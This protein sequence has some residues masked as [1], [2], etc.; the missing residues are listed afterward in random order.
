[1]QY[2]V[3]TTQYGVQNTDT[4]SQTDEQMD[5]EKRSPY[6]AFFTQCKRTYDSGLEG[7]QGE[8]IVTQFDVL[9]RHLLQALEKTLLD[10]RY[11]DLQNTKWECREFQ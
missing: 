2:S 9:F 10:D 6:Q 4:G 5:G 11:T 8:A 3:Q 1:M 7:R